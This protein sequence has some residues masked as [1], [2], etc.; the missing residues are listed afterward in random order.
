MGIV[1]GE[2]GNIT[3]SFI[4]GE[5]YFSVGYTTALR[6]VIGARL[7]YVSGT[8]MSLNGA[9]IIRIALAQPN[10]LVY[11]SLP[12][13]ASGSMTFKF[14]QRRIDSDVINDGTS[15]TDNFY[16]RGLRRDRVYT[17]TSSGWIGNSTTLLVGRLYKFIAIGGASF[18][19]LGTVFDSAN[20]IYTSNGVQPGQVGG[21]FNFVFMPLASSFMATA[22]TRYENNETYLDLEETSLPILI[23]GTQRLRL[24]NPNSIISRTIKYTLLSGSSV[25]FTTVYNAIARNTT[26]LENA[27]CYISMSGGGGG[28]AGGRTAGQTGPGGGGSGGYRLFRTVFP[29]VWTSAAVGSGGNGQSIINTTDPGGDG[30]DTFISSSRY[31]SSVNVIASGGKGGYWEPTN[32]NLGAGGDGGTNTQSTNPLNSFL[33][34]GI[35]NINGSRGGNGW[36]YTGS[37]GTT[38]ARGFNRTTNTQDGLAI[39]A[40]SGSHFGNL[41]KFNSQINAV[42]YYLFNGT[43]QINTGPLVA[44]NGG[45][46]A[47]SAGAGGGGGGSAF[48]NGGNGAIYNPLTSAQTGS[49]GSG[50]GGGSSGLLESNRRPGR[51]GGT[52]IINIFS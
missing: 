8:N 7:Q 33:Y 27:K 31:S 28:G 13:S 29:G 26:S 4:A 16:S 18:S 37:G 45:N 15:G 5:A 17:Y 32:T 3:A 10:S 51:N 41:Y 21:L 14:L 46:N 34:T 20:S 50:G 48:A 1:I 24:V 47:G 42:F 40:F 35:V 19:S 25:N 6:L 38:T 52:G 30:G 39:T 43:T 49:Y 12:P 22:M 9:E 36:N 2:S 11:L 44:R 23:A